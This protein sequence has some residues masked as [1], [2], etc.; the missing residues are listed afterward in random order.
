MWPRTPASAPAPCPGSST[1][2]RR[3]AP[4]TRARVLAA[5]EVLDYRPNPLARGLSLGRC[6]TVGVVVPF[7]THASAVERLRGVVAALRRQPLRPRA[8]QRRVARAPRRALRRRSPAATGPTA[9]SSCRSRRRP[10]DLDRLR[11]RRRARRARRRRA[12]TA[13][14][15]SSPTTSRAAASP[16]G[17]SST[18]ATSASRSSATTPTTRFGFTVERAARARLRGGAA[19]SRASRADP[20]LVAPRPARPRRR[21]RRSPTELL[22]LRRPPDRRLRVVRRAGHR[23]AR[24]GR[25]R[26]PPGARR[27]VGRRLRRHRALRPTSGSRP[28]AS[29]CSTAATSAP[30]CCSTRSTAATAP[31]AAERPRAAARAR[32][33]GDHRPRRRR[34]RTARG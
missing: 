14:R 2:A 32:R 7:F 11:R 26:R 34:R 31:V 15:R 24:G 25:G 12:A 23:R 4:T 6:Q 18:S 5:I 17:T 13:C 8:V 29:R 10:A 9:C 1:T 28:C 33:A 20:S 16:P 22:A 21:P 27:P 3:S 19:T 30:G